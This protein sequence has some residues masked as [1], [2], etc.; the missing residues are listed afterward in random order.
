M[1]DLRFLK[2]L[3]AEFERVA[4]ARATNRRAVARLWWWI[5]VPRASFR[6]FG[7]GLSGLVVVGVVA[8][9]L[10][11]HEAGKGTSATTPSRQRLVDILGVL[12]RPQTKADLSLP[13][14]SRVAQGPL[15]AL[16]GTPDQALVRLATV[17][18]WGEKVFLVP[19]KP[20]TAAELARYPRLAPLIARRSNRGETI[21]LFA[22]NGG[23]GAETA[24]QVEAGF[25]SMS[26][27][28]GRT[29]A[30]GATASRIFFAVPDGVAK[31][32]FVFPR[33]ASPQGPI[34]PHTL[35]VTA[36]VHGNVAA[37]QVDREAGGAPPRIIWYAADGRVIKRIGNFAAANRIVRS[38]KPAPE[39]PLSRAAERNPA[40]P[41]QVRVLP[42][43]GGADSAF[44]VKFR[45]LLNDA[46]YTYI[47][48][49]PTRPGCFGA[50]GLSTSH[51]GGANDIRGSLY[52]HT[53]RAA[54]GERWC[55]GTYR[56]QVS[57]M[58]LG[59]YGPLRHPAAPF[60]TTTFTVH[61]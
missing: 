58:D 22:G 11:T 50:R 14:L 55:V 5:R 51:G 2:E 13:Y 7:L 23:A 31:V 38:P 15:S 39:T 42:R 24:D 3:E 59:R 37:V 32:A 56:V 40:T 6:M 4:E 33:Q 1:S 43:T 35:T 34:Y 21:S 41:N 18:P 36:V 8:V 10:S 53:F 44:T 17:T 20:P 48:S 49:G 27:G 19:F 61:P 57:V 52:G 16:R 30:G 47:V 60:G 12:R 45:V 9:A 54:P 25:L 46:D 29:F 28:A 26:Q